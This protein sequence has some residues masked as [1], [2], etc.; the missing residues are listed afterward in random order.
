MDSAGVFRDQFTSLV[1]AVP[2]ADGKK[3][4]V[5]A[6]IQLTSVWHIHDIKLWDSYT[7]RPLWIV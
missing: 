4:H 6:N 5:C 3:V 1:G 7:E 2:L